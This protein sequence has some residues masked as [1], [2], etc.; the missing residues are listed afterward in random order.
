MQ[1]LFGKQTR[2]LLDDDSP[3]APLYPSP[4]PFECDIYHLFVFERPHEVRPEIRI[5]QRVTINVNKV[6]TLLTWIGEYSRPVEGTL[7]YPDRR[8]D[9]A[10][11]NF[12]Q[13]CFGW[14]VWLQRVLLQDL[15]VPE[16][17]FA[18]K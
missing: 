15:E 14:S 6:A 12:N 1:T 17:Y 16:P 4:P 11:P 5:L 8:Q 7:K 10:R 18:I 13:G 2:L 9:K 3:Y